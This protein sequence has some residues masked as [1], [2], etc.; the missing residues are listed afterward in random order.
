[1]VE[2]YQNLKNPPI[3]EVVLGISIE[4]SMEEINILCSELIKEYP[5]KKEIKVSSIEGNEN[6]IQSINQDVNGYILQTEDNLVKVFI[7]K[8]RIA[9]SVGKKYKSFEI[10]KK[11]YLKIIDVLQKKLHISK[12]IG[13]IGLRFI[14]KIE[15]VSNIGLF[16]IQLSIN[17]IKIFPFFTRFEQ[18]NK[19][20]KS[21]IIVAGNQTKDN[22]YEIILDIDT[23]AQISTLSQI[24]D[25]LER[26]R[27]EKNRI[28][29]S[30]FDE[31][32]IKNWE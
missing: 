21:I 28:F 9:Y 11:E 12:G 4:L 18:N 32:L 27:R 23:H 10:L 8:N 30:S 3:K 16:N 22:S 20:I 2:S 13:E 15:N 1:M 24:T 26:M 25:I 19:D 17:K 29:F 14:N 31:S 6:G 5:I 7:E